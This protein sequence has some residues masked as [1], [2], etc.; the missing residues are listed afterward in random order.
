MYLVEETEAHV[1]IRV[2]LLLNLLLS[3][4][5]RGARSGSSGSSGDGE[6]GGI[7]KVSLDLLDV[8]I[9]KEKGDTSELACH[10]QP[11][12]QLNEVLFTRM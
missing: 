10:V 12:F 5:G 11:E 6:S 1:V 3:L 2:L 9:G 8:P 7:S 4:G